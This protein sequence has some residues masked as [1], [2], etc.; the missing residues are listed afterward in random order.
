MKGGILMPYIIQTNKLT[1]SIGGRQLVTDISLHVKKGEIYGFLGPN[2]AGKTTVMKMITNLW[3]P[4][5]GTVEIMGEQ[6]RN[7]SYGILKRMGSIIE[8]PVFYEGLS[9]EDNLK[10][11]CEYMGFYQK[12]SVENSLK[13]LDLTEAAKKPVKEYSLGMKQRLGIA[14]AILSG[15]ELLVLDEP[16]NGLDPA[17]KKQ[18][19]ELLRRL[20]EENE[21]T[22]F[23]SSHMLSEIENIAD[24]VGVISRGRMQR[25][26]SMKDIAEKNL[27]FIE[28]SVNDVKRA[29]YILADRMNLQNFKVLDEHKIRVY[30]LSVP[31][32]ELSKALTLGK[33]EVEAIGR[34][35][36][37]LEDYF[38]KVTEG[39][40]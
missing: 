23:I 2:G 9:G 8:F 40:R 24:T 29:A 1:K 35:S 15:P 13:L 31:A 36:E 39:G 16:T 25:E 30:D 4:T 22:I 20:M 34:Q 26:V 14:R 27:A 19:R 5:E 12:G 17:G 32:G 38:M 37:S 6:L 7:D 28:I 3:K 10:L 33:I 18:I 21:T 11:H